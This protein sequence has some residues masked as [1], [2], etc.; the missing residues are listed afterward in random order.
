MLERRAPTPKIVREEVSHLNP[1]KDPQRCE[2]TMIREYTNNN[3][4]R[5]PETQI[6]GKKERKLSK[7]KA[8]L[9][10]LQEV[11]KKNS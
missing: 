11:P 2:V 1:L 10:R 9:E 4:K 6:I 8:K 7:K 5:N 3:G